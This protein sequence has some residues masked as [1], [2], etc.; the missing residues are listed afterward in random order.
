MH[1]P[2]Y[3]TITLVAEFVISGVI[4]YTFYK[5]Y[6]EGKFQTALAGVALAYEILFNISY[7]ARRVPNPSSK[8]LPTPYI[9][10]AAFHGILSLVMFL[11][12]IVYLFLAWKNYKKEINYFK[13][14]KTFTVIFLFFWTISVVT[15]LMFYL[16]EYVL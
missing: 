8:V 2:L 13:K 12:L 6:K 10:L 11:T 9:A 4:F 1:P 15:G 5:G 3:S 14:H 7:M 16:V